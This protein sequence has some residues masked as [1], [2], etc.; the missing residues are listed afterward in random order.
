VIFAGW[1]NRRGFQVLGVALISFAVVSWAWRP[2]RLRFSWREWRPHLVVL[3]V[4]L[5]AI[6]ANLIIASAPSTKIDELYYH[7]LTP[8]RLMEDGALLAY[9]QPF[10]ASALPQMQFQTSLAL[11]HAWGWPDLGNLASAFFSILLAGF[12]YCVCVEET[13]SRPVSILLASTVPVG[14]YA[15]VHH[16]TSGPHALGDLALALA[17]VAILKTE[18]LAE[19]ARAWQSMALVALCATVSASTKISLWPLALLV[20]LI[21]AWRLGR[22]GRGARYWGAIALAALL[23]W[24]ICQGP[25]LALSWR[26]TG[27]P[28]GPFFFGGVFGAGAPAELASETVNSRIVN[29]TGLLL[30][31]RDVAI[32]VSPFL[33]MAIVALVWPRRGGLRMRWL[34]LALL[35]AQLAL[36]AIALPHHFRFLSGLMFA[37]VAASAMHWAG[38]PAV[39]FLERHARIASLLLLG[40]WLGAQIYYAAPFA[41]V[42]AGLTS[43][44]DFIDRYVALAADFR[45]LDRLLPPQAVLLTDARLPAFYAPR[46]VLF[47]WRDLHARA[48]VYYLSVGEP[49]RLEGPLDCATEVYRNADAIVAAYR[50]P[51]VPPARGFVGVYA[52][53]PLR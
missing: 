40:P 45:A 24:L 30:A 14:L 12:L 32:N 33:P 23:P 19:R 47:T 25:M 41:R 42:F 18:Q 43:K 29:Q 34:L 17:C 28:F 51:L 2:L 44:R 16:T 50:N 26:L 49:A 27:A 46:P 9:L 7:M 22:V 3:L 39:A 21:H 53:A 52:C 48:P 4:P 5:L 13:R 11:A 36:I 10:V 15:A 1:A 38:S 37:A 31:L 20:T 35:A 8:K 6:A